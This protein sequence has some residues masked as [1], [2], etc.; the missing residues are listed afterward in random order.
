[1]E[2]I[3]KSTK[4]AIYLLKPYVTDYT[5][6]LESKLDYKTYDFNDRIEVEGKVIVGKTKTRTPKWKELLQQGVQKQ[7]PDIS[8]SSNRAVVFFKINS[9]IFAIP[10]GYGKHL[11]KEE[12]IERDFGLKTALNIIN[13]DK[14]VSVD[15]ANI[16]NLT[17]QTRTQASKKGGPASFD[18]DVIKDLLRSV[19]GEPTLVLPEEFGSIVTGNEGIYISPNINMLQIPSIL[20]KLQIEYK[21]DLYK[22]RFDWIDN[23][24]TEKDPT[25]LDELREKLITDLKAH[26][27]EDVSIVPPYIIDWSIFEGISYTPKGEIF[28]DYNIE[29]FYS[30]KE[31]SV[32]D[33]DWEKLAKLRIYLKDSTQISSIPTPIW[34]YISYETEHNGFRYAFTLSNWYKINKTYFEEIYNYCKDFEESELTFPDAKLIE[35]EGEY[36]SRFAKS[37]SSLMLLD[38]KLVK[39][40]TARSSIEVCDVFSNTKE[41]IHIKIRYSSATLSHLFSQGRISAF[42]L[43]KDRTYRKNLRKKIAAD[44]LGKN[45]IP[46]ESRDLTNSD[47]TITYALIDKKNRSFVDS[48][49]FFSLVNFRLTSE[50]LSVMGFNIRVKNIIRK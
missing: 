28:T 41:F 10:F 19:T 24:K 22:E 2:I 30:T 47:Y 1:M 42:S 9:R 40:D 34:R 13:A 11:I 33:L 36:N 37:S 14:L 43:I 44:G 49:P 46:L 6:A 48:L 25:V 27:V 16:G 17:V 15:R 12:T 18:I 8:N 31:E 4:L 5:Q 38:Q 50:E 3:K 45:L 7:I 32:K 20:S 21:K 39:S 35:S 23:I 29:D 26:N